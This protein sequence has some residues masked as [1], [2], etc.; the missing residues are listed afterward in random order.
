M[1][2]F[3]SRPLLFAVLA[4]LVAAPL[5]ALAD[6]QDPII[7]DDGASLVPTTKAECYQQVTRCYVDENGWYLGPDIAAQQAKDDPFATETAAAKDIGTNA[8]ER[9]ANAPLVRDGAAVAVGILGAATETVVDAIERG[10]RSEDHDITSIDR[11]DIKDLGPWLQQ[12]QSEGKARVT[13][14]E[15]EAAE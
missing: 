15:K 4:A 5:P 3:S 1:T 10:Y 2:R 14:Q 12:W 13:L 6:T 7:G 8:V 9:L 11:S